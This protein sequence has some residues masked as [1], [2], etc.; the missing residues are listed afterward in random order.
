VVA[1]GE[2][3]ASVARRFRTRDATLRRVNQLGR[4]A[5]VR[6]GDIVALPAVARLRSGSL[7][8]DA[9]PIPARVG[10]LHRENLRADALGL[11][12]MGTRKTL[13]H[14]VHTHR[15]LPVP[16]DGR[17][18]RVVQVPEWRRVTRPWTRT[19]LYQAGAAVDALFDGRLR[20]TA[21][22]RTE[23]VQSD[24]AAWNG[25]AA[26]AEGPRRSSHLTG[27][28]V[29]LS[30]VEHSE[31]EIEWLR[32]VLAR[33]EARGLLMAVEEFVQPHF[34]VMVLPAYARYA[35]RLRSPVALGGC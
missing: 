11:S 12:R 30:K 29:D 4:N 31:E 3:L 24:L 16:D 6:A 5:A 1:P 35:A 2:T 27:A 19:F 17:G 25:N 8:A 34:H 18:F 13:E 10:D 9:P 28:S 22:T 20:V 33:L 26:P 21:L 15:L 32:L 14:F 7:Q 23:A